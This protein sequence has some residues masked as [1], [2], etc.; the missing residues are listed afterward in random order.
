MKQWIQKLTGLVLGTFLAVSLSGKATANTPEDTTN[1][2]PD[3]PAVE[4][5]E[6]SE[7]AASEETPILISSAPAQ[8]AVTDAVLGDDSEEEDFPAADTDDETDPL[9]VPIVREEQPGFDTTLTEIE[10]DAVVSGSG[11]GVPVSENGADVPAAPAT[12]SQTDPIPPVTEL[13]PSAGEGLSDGTADPAVE[14]TPAPAA[15]A[16]PSSVSLN[17]TAPIR[18]LSDSPVLRSLEEETPE[19]PSQDPFFDQQGNLFT[20]KYFTDTDLVLDATGE[21]I[22]IIVEGINRI[23]GIISSIKKITIRGGGDLVFTDTSP[24]ELSELNLDEVNVTFQGAGDIA[25]VN[26]TAGS[27]SLTLAGGS[28]IGSIDTEGVLTLYTGEYYMDYSDES[29][30]AIRGSIAGGGELCLNS[31]VYA[32]TASKDSDTEISYGYPLVY[33][34]SGATGSASYGPLHIQPSQAT[35]GLTTI[36]TEAYRVIEEE[37]R[38]EMDSSSNKL[39]KTLSFDT[40]DSGSDEDAHI[41]VDDYSGTDGKIDLADI[42][43]MIDT[44]RSEMEIFQPVSIVEILR[45]DDSDQLHSEF[46][47]YFSYSD[48]DEDGTET[49]VYRNDLTKTV[50]ADDVYLIR[51]TFIFSKG[52]PWGGG[53]V[54]STTTSFTGSGI[55]GGAGAGSVRLSSAIGDLRVIV[56]EEVMGYRVHVYSGNRE[57]T[58]LGGRKVKASMSFS[59]PQGWNSGMTFAVFKNDDGSLTA[60]RAVYDP[61]TGTLTFD[62]DRTGDFVLVSL[63]YDGELFSAGFYAALSRLPEVQRFLK[64]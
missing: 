63:D 35:T 25:A 16:L 9:P 36:P 8:D 60:F 22:E 3:V 59:L 58:D 55:L 32:I 44:L 12:V 5:V 27:S 33:D 20:M 29:V 17:N 49:P 28:D 4:I 10:D 56:T 64:A 18:L 24:V 53:T 19:E 26:N 40:G 47:Q 14:T 2:L 50:P 11:T 7:T 34:L 43:S 62:T 6:K 37:L 1:E 39:G 52:A 21:E 57:I 45:K 23:R 51:I 46:Y 38:G 15:D 30:T 42:K 13:I 41:P 54:S 48:T 31:G 61:L